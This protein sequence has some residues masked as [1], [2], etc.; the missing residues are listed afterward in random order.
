MGETYGL[1][2][3]LPIAVVV[4][5]AIITKK[6]I[7]PL[8]LGTVVGAILLYGFSFFPN[9]V[10]DLLA[11]MSDPD[12][13]WTMV[14]PALFGI[15]IAMFGQSNAGTAF[16]ELAIKYVK[17]KQN[18]LLATYIFGII[19]F[20]DEYMNA[21]LIGGTM[22]NL[23]DKFKVPREVLAY[24]TNSTGTPV[25]VLLPF[26]SW[27]VFLMGL[28]GSSELL[29]GDGFTTYLS[30]IPF[31]VYPM[32]TLI[33]VLLFI[34]RKVPMTKYVKE[35]VAR[36]EKGN[37]FP[38]GSGPD[39]EGFEDELEENSGN[40]KKPRL[41]NFVLPIIVLVA[42]TIMFDMD[43]IIGVILAIVT[44][45]ILYRLNGT[46]TYSEL[47]D[48][49]VK[50]IQ[51]MVE[52]IVLIIAIFLLVRVNENLGTIEYVITS[53]EP[54]ITPLLL[55]GITLLVVAFLGFTTGNY[56][57]TM[58]IVLPIILPLTQMSDVNTSLVL[59]AMVSGG[60]FGSHVCFF[61]DAVT[62]TS[63]STQVSNMSQIRVSFPYALAGLIL[64][65]FIF[66]GL[67]L[68]V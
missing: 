20:M 61:G 1:L 23:T 12:V 29:D 33:I 47:F 44:C 15:L 55:P 39:T 22:R 7:E 56:W 64:S 5:T 18:S 51:D 31:M 28:Y 19:I 43:L 62:L 2:S 49:S 67:G 53:V 37:L 63:A 30:T 6:V 25:S 45:F 41:I 4:I 17:N 54:L 52:L 59:G 42:G 11:T 16:R 38:E 34:F 13:V 26:S 50:G 46:M 32:I 27:A 10:G 57:G 66:L 14:I 3:L 9:W 8:I 68:I 40:T 35:A 65:F 48:T 36:A 21:L 24:V 58:G 60:V